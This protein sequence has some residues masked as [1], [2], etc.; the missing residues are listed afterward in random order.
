M[1]HAKMRLLPRWLGLPILIFYLLVTAW[2]MMSYDFDD[3]N[4]NWH[5]QMAA[6]PIFAFLG[7]AALL[8]ALNSRQ[9]S[10]DFT[11]VRLRSGPLPGAG[12]NRF[13][14]IAEIRRCISPLSCR[15]LEA[16]R[17]EV[18]YGSI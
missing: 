13:I 16:I 3:R 10:I 5:G 12:G 17:L 8:G 18:L 15:S 9:A 7:Y 2:M 11:G 6:A 4:P 1:L 14:P